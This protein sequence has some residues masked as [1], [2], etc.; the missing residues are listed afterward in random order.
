MGNH[1]IIILGSG[2][3]GCT[4]AI[5]TAR[6]GLSPLMFAGIR[7]GGQLMTTTD[8]ENFPGF[9]EPVPGPEL[10]DRMRKQVER[11]GVAVV[12][13]DVSRVD[14]SARPFRLETTE[15]RKEECQALIVATGADAQW[16]GL[17]SETRLR[18][19][20]VSAC[21]TCDG[22][23]FRGK[24]VALVGGGDSAME[25]TLFLAR[26]ASKVTLVHR[27]SEFRASKL[28]QER[29][30][31]HPRIAFSLDSV[32]EEVLGREK[33]SG[34]RLKNVKTGASSELRCEGLF[35]AIGH[36]PNTEL[37]RGQLELDAK[38]YIVTDGRSRTSVAGVFAAGDVMDPHYRQAV[39]SAGA[40]CQAALE[41]ERYLSG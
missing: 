31:S 14:L 36:K 35:V 38:G 39:T 32:V 41:A 30:R 15:G 19:K 2:P 34:V 9:P 21:A 29:V 40:G 1:K 13:E 10:M 28:M 3:A 5:Y 37:F 24:E 11:L 4:A 6:A 23:F 20:G 8:V 18:G 26:F 12:Q 22:F 16:L 27:R 17:E 25:E 33:V 7:A